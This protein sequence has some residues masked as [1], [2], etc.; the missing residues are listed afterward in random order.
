[1]VRKEMRWEGKVYFHTD[2]KIVLKYSGSENLR[3]P[4]FETN[5]VRRI[6]ELTSHRSWGYINTMLNPTDEGSR[7]LKIG[8]F[9][10]DNRWLSGPEFLKGG[11]TRGLVTDED[12]VIEVY[13]TKTEDEVLTDS[14]LEVC[15]RLSKWNRALRV[16][17]KVLTIIAAVAHRADVK[18]GRSTCEPSSLITVQLM[19][20]AELVV[21]RLEQEKQFPAEI[22]AAKK[23]KLPGRESK[24]YRL[25]PVM[26]D[27]ILQVGGR[28]SNVM[29]NTDSRHPILLAR[30]S[31]ASRLLVDHHHRLMGHMGA[32]Q[33]LASLRQRFWISNG[34][35]AV[36]NTLL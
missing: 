12:R 27:G 9:V 6:R 13:Q 15:H 32:S 10:E 5:R 34:L 7:G 23:G 4:V 19:A 31:D 18:Q 30:K 16:V 26:V 2:S 28:L 35:A 20:K 33:V 24:I 29:Y 1:M 14:I 36:K 3:L 22:R 21:V 8:K 11:W 17:A 25:N